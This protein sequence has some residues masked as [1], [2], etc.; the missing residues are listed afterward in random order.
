ML[1]E[2]TASPSVRIL[3]EAL[4]SLDECGLCVGRL[5]FLDLAT[6]IRFVYKRGFFLIKFLHNIRRVFEKLIV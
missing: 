4:G 1:F 5:L 2:M 6:Y 3:I